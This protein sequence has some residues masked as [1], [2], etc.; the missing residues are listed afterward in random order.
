MTCSF[1]PAE[2]A[3]DT[4]RHHTL[5]LID[6]TVHKVWFPLCAMCDCVVRMFPGER[7]HV[8]LTVAVKYAAKV[9]LGGG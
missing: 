2:M 7:R 6:K 5:C 3:V 9:G 4:R 1:C 8:E